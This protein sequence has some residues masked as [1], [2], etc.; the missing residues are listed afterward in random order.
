M[1]AM[2]THPGKRSPEELLRQVQAEERGA[3]RGQLKI[4]LGYASGVGKSQRM[5]AEGRRRQMRGQDVV[6]GA[7]QPS[8]PCDAQ[9][10]LTQLE[11]IPERLVSGKPVM[12][13]DAILRRRPAVCMIDGLAYD[14]PPGF[15]HQKRWQDVEEILSAGISVLTSLNLQYI[16][17]H[18]EQVERISGKRVTTTVPVDFIREA[19][20]LEIVDASA[21]AGSATSAHN[22]SGSGPSQQ[23]KLQAL[24]EIALLLA[25]DVV[26]RQLTKYL[27]L[28][29][30]QTHWGTHERIL[31]C[32]TPRSDALTIIKSGQ[33]DSTRVHGELYVVYVRQAELSATDQTALDGSLDLARQA[34]AQIHVL[35]GEDPIEAIGNFARSQGITQIFIGHSRQE[36]WRTHWFGDPVDRL[37]RSV[38]GIDIQVFPHV[39]TRK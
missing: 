33:R 21:D 6:V 7:I 11:V 23:Q 16:E 2:R 38:K 36:S 19:D 25:A 4:I 24:R 9:K 37:I 28:E 13:L 30:L 1:T 29:G 3:R 17:E 12:D 26:D 10:L 15:R 39:G 5:L 20:E 8:L 32:I 14:N 31:V 34:G 35:E 27:Q 18:R 22:T